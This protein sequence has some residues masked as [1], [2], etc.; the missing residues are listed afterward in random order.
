MIYVYIGLALAWT[1]A[2]GFAGYRWG[3]SVQK[4][5]QAEAASI[6]TGIGSKISG[7]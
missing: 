7:K 6:L 2:A 1:V 4:K 3:A 5:A